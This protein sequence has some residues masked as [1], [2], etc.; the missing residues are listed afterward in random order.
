MIQAPETIGF[1]TA[2]V[3]R[4]GG[5]RTQ[6][7]DPNTQN[8]QNFLTSAGI[9]DVDLFDVVFGCLY[10]RSKEFKSREPNSP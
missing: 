10:L 9:F 2:S 1:L 3:K 8:G 7:I 4:C 6:T 5:A